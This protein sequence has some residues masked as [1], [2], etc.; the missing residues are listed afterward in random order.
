MQSLPPLDPT[1]SPQPNEQ[2]RAKTF[3]CVWT[4]AAQRCVFLQAVSLF[5]VCNR[6]CSSGRFHHSSL[7]HHQFACVCAGVTFR[8][9][10]PPFVPHPAACLRFFP[11]PSSRQR[12]A[13]PLPP[14]NPR[15]LFSCLL[16]L[17]HP[18]PHAVLFVT[19][20]CRAD[21]RHTRG[22]LLLHHQRAGGVFW[23][24]LLSHP[25]RRHSICG[26]GA[27]RLGG[28]GGGC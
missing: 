9:P 23:W 2:Q 27:G 19:K 14:I 24:C 28:G 20:P 12:A 3:V 26:C 4:P 16:L 10:S 1:G 22:V 11:A 7:P 15:P 18:P 21:L 25:S 5:L 8:P 6:A 13:R 17:L